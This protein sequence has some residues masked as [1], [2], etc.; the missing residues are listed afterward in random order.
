MVNYSMQERQDMYEVFIK[1]FKN[2]LEACRRYELLYPE[3][4]QP[5]H[6]TI[7]RIYK[8]MCDNGS[9]EKKRK[10][11]ESRPG[12][13]DINVLA[14]IEIDDSGSCRSI[15]RECGLSK[16]GVNKILRKHKLHDYKYLPV[17]RLHAGDPERRLEF[18]EWLLDQSA[19]DPLFVNRVVWTDESI[20]T[21]NGVFNR[22]NKHYYATENRHA[23]QPVRNQ[24]RFSLNVWCGL[25]D[26]KLIGPYFLGGTL[27]GNSYLEFLQTDFENLLE[28]L[29]VQTF[30]NISWF[31]HDGAPPA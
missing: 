13:N 12:V 2:S 23:V 18:C 7:L 25:I 27:N 21:N 20:F 10:K 9:L 26:N 4:N 22:R 6:K 16:S 24:I 1:S 28:Q 14:Q 15:A 5:S 8:N 30:A 19:D 17:Q 29:P 11:R 3:R 31:Q